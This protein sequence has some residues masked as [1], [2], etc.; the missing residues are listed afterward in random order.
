VSSRQRVLVVLPTLP[1]PPRQQGVAIRYGL[2]LERLAQRFDISLAIITSSPEEARADLGPVRSWCVGVHIHLRSGY[3]P[4]AWRRA[5]LRLSRWQS[6]GVPYRLAAHD[7]HEIRAFL[8]GVAATGEFD[9]IVWVGSL[10]LD[11]GLAVF[12]AERIVWDPIDSIAL[13]VS[14]ESRKVENS[15][16]EAN[17]LLAWERWMT[18]R[19][20]LTTYV[21]PIDAAFVRGEGVSVGA[22]RVVPNG[23]YVGDMPEIAPPNLR[24]APRTIGF[25][26][27][28]SYPPNVI[29]ACRLA[30]IVARVRTR[31]HEVRLLIIG[32]DPDARVRALASDSVEVTGTVPNVWTWIERV[33]LFAFPM[34]TGAGLQNKLLEAMYAKRVVI[35]TDVCNGGIQGRSEEHLL[36][37]ETDEDFVAAIERLISSPETA[38]EIAERG[39]ALVQRAFDWDSILPGIATLWASV[40][41]TVH[42]ARILPRPYGRP[43]A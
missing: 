14:R 31:G 38:R 32:R 39:H 12:P 37:A 23:V 13:H 20:H 41:E 24:S 22:I 30:E 27:N 7:T 40:P 2:I 36:L 26:G 15:A 33:D 10:H 35:C 6:T 9:T 25:L 5:R 8:E 18:G 43:G 17:D 19:V 28:M 29:A 16:R 3:R 1:Y 42:G 11:A 34:T 21:S 4:N